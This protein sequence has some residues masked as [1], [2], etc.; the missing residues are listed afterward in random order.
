ML[1]C[2][3]GLLF[4]YIES[5]SLLLGFLVLKNRR[6][7]SIVESRATFC[8]WRPMIRP[9]IGRGPQASVVGVGDDVGVGVGEA[10]IM[11]AGSTSRR[12]PYPIAELLS[13]LAVFTFAHPTMQC[14]R[15]CLR[16]WSAF[17]AVATLGEGEGSPGATPSDG[18][19][20]RSIRETS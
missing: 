8:S 2:D 7:I 3:A 19:F 20:V 12:E 14:L 15:R 9:F 18:T 10:A 1:D 16:A 5:R 4:G 13:L 11:Q 6:F 17:V